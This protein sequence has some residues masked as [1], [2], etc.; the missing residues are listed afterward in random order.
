MKNR[1][2]LAF[3]LGIALVILVAGISRFDIISVDEVRAPELRL[4]EGSATTAD[5]LGRVIITVRNKQGAV[6][7]KG[8]VVE[9]DTT[10]IAFPISGLVLPNV[11]YTDTGSV[12]TTEG[13]PVGFKITLKGTPTDDT[14]NIW[15]VAITGPST[16]T[17]E[18]VDT[19]GFGT[20]INDV[21][22]SSVVWASIDSLKFDS[23][24]AAGPDSIVLQLTAVRGVKLATSGSFFCA[25]VV[26]SDSMLDNGLGNICVF[27]EALIKTKPG[28]GVYVRSGWPLVAADAG[29][30]HP[31]PIAQ[32][33]ADSLALNY[34][35][36]IVGYA[37]GNK[38]DVSDTTNVWMF[39]SPD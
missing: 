19:V 5:S 20:T 14:L 34:T 12:I 28:S 15:G 17:H 33:V 13:G 36:K 21:L 27:G 16:L 38:D 7:H 35:G 1:I 2:L 29:I 24:A 32:F 37:L 39:V 6:V 30:V 8:R 23:G 4:G 10:F 11:K 31:L 18:Y 22:Y 26:T 3:G 25:G 9:W